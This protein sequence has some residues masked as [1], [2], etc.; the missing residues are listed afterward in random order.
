MLPL[1]CKIVPFE[2]VRNV[3]KDYPPTLLMH[4]TKDTDVPYEQSAMMAEELKRHGVDHELITVEGGGHSLW[5]GDR[6]KID[7]AFARSVEYIH[8]ALSRSDEPN[9]K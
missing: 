4:G 5:G 3:T 7:Q 8:E 2:P 1:S 9:P 6:E